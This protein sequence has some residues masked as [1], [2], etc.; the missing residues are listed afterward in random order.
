MEVDRRVE[1]ARDMAVVEQRQR[2][3]AARRYRGA[4]APPAAAGAESS[5]LGRTFTVANNVDV[6]TS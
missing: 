1:E 6:W 4:A 5:A 2:R 3:M